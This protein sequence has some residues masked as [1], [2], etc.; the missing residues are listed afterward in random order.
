MSSTM[1]SEVGLRAH[2]RR[3][4]DASCSRRFYDYGSAQ[5]AGALAADPSK[6]AKWRTEEVDA[7]V[8]FAEVLQRAEQ[9]P[10]SVA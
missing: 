6:A 10:M 9:P 7:A 8:S 4:A 5:M 3:M 2:V 1:R